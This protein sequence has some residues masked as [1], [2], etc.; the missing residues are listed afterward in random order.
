[1]WANLTNPTPRNLWLFRK[2]LLSPPIL[3]PFWFLDGAQSSHFCILTCS[4]YSNMANIN[5]E[6]MQWPELALENIQVARF[7]PRCPQTRRH[8][9]PQ[10]VSITCKFLVCSSIQH[11]VVVSR[12]GS[13]MSVSKYYFS[14]FPVFRA[15]IASPFRFNYQNSPSKYKWCCTPLP[16]TA[17]MREPTVGQKKR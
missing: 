3:A 10:S 16:R 15:I 6:T 8:Y 5:M 17:T 13:H 12:Q 9:S 4:V 7:T 11:L 14:F 1:M 2:S